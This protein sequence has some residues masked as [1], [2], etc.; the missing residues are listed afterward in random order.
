MAHFAKLG[1]N[2]KVIQVLTLDN[3]N[4]LNA[5][6][7]EDESVGQYYLEQHNNW[8]AQMWIQTSYN[9]AGGI[10][11]LGGTPFR[12]NYAGIGFTW[13]EDNNIF[14][15]KKPFAS[16]VLNTT[17]ALWHSPIGDAP[18]LG[19]ESETH[20]Y[21]WNESNKSWDKTTLAPLI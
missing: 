12:G 5:D 21:K 18:D 4:M 13:D 8:P 17:D 15:G 7:V 6:G 20:L 11:K 10:H 19:A 2:S 16:W 14:Y 3:K 9:T 1:S